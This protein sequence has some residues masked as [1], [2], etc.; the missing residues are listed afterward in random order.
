MFRQILNSA[1]KI[2]T[3]PARKP[4][5]HRRGS[6]DL[7]GHQLR[8]DGEAPLN[9]QTKSHHSLMGSDAS[10]SDILFFVRTQWPE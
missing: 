2:S 3:K 5:N 8:P 10:E 6:P 4:P 1:V 9:R 7:M